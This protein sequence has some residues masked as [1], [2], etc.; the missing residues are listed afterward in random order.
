MAENEDA[1]A[2]VG[3]STY[4]MDRG[5]KAGANVVTL[6]SVVSVSPPVYT[7][8]EDAKE[9]ARIYTEV[10]GGSCSYWSPVAMAYA[11][12]HPL[13]L[14]SPSIAK[15]FA[16]NG[17][18]KDDIRRYLYDNTWITAADAERWAYY[19]G[20]TGFSLKR[21]VEQCLLPVEYHESDDPQRRV[22]VFQKPEWIGI[23]VAGDPGRNQSKAYCS[24][25]TQG[26][27]VSREIE[28]PRQWDALLR[29][30]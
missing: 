9:H 27:P 18:S 14:M 7:G 28:L 10:I 11:K 12:Y 23:V 25:H 19:V 30:A 26:P 8:S 3:W 4:A 17:W 1:C 16:A 22:R 2:E 24:N 15:V 6:Q 21:Q 5:F 13:I 29:K 20:L